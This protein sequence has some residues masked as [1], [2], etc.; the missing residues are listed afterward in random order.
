M[1]LVLMAV[2]ISTEAADVSITAAVDPNVVPVGSEVTLVVTVKGKFG[3][4]ES[5]EL[6]P[7]ADFSV[8]QAGTSQSFSFGTGGASS[9]LQYTY[10]LVPKKPGTY[11]IEPIRFRAGDK[12]YTADPV[13]LEV[14][15]SPRQMPVPQSTEKSAPDE[16]ADQ[17]IFIRATVDKDTVFV[18]Q[19]VTWTLGFYTDGRLNMMRTPEYSPPPAEG[20]WAEELPS[21][22]SYYKQIQGRQYL[23]NEVKRAFFAS[24]PGEFTIGQAQVNLVIDDFGQFPRDRFFDD[25]FNRSFGSFG[26]G[27]PVSLK[28]KEIAVTVLPLPTRGR[29]AD[30]SGLVGRGLELSVHA[31]KNVAQVGE[32]ITV[33]LEIQ[34]EGNFKTM[35]APAIPQ[36]QGFKMYESGTSSDLFKKDDIVSGRKKYE[37][38]LIPQLEGDKT[39]PPVDLSYFDAATKTYK[40][41]QSEPIHLEVKPGTAEEGRRVVFTGSG[42][43]IEVLGKDINYIHPVPAVIRPASRTVMESK[44]YL[45]AHAVPFIALLLSIVV[46]RKRKRLRDDVRLARSSRAAREAEKKLDRARKLLKQGQKAEVYTLVSSALRGYFAD[47]MNASVEGLTRDDLE[48]FLGTKGVREEAVEELGSILAACDSARYAP[49]ISDAGAVSEAA[50]GEGARDIVTRA[51]EALKNIDK[52]HLS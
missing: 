44:F 1:T 6:P 46:E 34:G 38:V 42:E 18:N 27:K 5:P 21:Q 24:A 2:A 9:S 17:P 25:F 41:I 35:A 45:A 43:D 47:K 13:T 50:A 36:P 19:Q 22:K 12:I 16:K 15:Q 4:S 48:R 51:A 49:G 40:T 7:L 37:Y 3:K 14:V 26:F 20:F 30:F 52:G 11:T 23:V 10:V 31:D 32:P 28:T 39:I 33:T 29:P 8:Y